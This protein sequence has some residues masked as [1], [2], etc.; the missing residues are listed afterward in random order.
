MSKKHNKS[1]KET[2]ESL[3]EG[4]ISLL[5]DYPI[6]DIKVINICKKV[7]IP[8]STFYYNFNDKYE[9]LEYIINNMADDFAKEL[10]KNEP[11]DLN[12][13]YS[14]LRFIYANQMKNKKELYMAILKNDK[15][16][17]A[18]KVLFD[19]L[20]NNV[21]KRLKEE[22]QKGVK[23]SIPTDIIAEYYA[24]GAYRVIV[25]CMDNIQYTEEEVARY[26]NTIITHSFILDKT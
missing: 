16:N 4:L 21:K 19:K 14:N 24:G 8:R 7:N 25:Y 3:S 6:E 11:E 26:I 1:K 5:K 17:H 9:L 13:Y 20:C 18:L 12:E 22:E 10:S 23:F 15:N 2:C